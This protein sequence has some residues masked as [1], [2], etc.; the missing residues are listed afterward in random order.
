MYFMFPKLLYQ[1]NGNNGLRDLMIIHESVSSVPDLEIY[2][3][4]IFYIANAR[5][6]LH[7]WNNKD[8]DIR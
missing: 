4:E 5:M 8:L 1:K 2:S 7:I 6:Y 3:C